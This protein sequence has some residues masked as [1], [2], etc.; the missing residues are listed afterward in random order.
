MV[1]LDNTRIASIL[2]IQVH[3]IEFT[4][5]H[6]KRKQNKRVLFRDVF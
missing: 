3:N 6:H 1:K 4:I 2:N 5:Y